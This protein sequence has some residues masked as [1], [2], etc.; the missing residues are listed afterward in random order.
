MSKHG[1][2][3][4]FGPHETDTD[5]LSGAYS[6]NALSDEERTAFEARMAESDEIRTE[7]A[8]LN[9]TALLLGR[10]VEPVQPSAAL[11]SSILDL[12]DST[13]QLPKLEAEGSDGRDE[14]TTT[15]AAPAPAEKSGEL[16]EPIPLARQ[17]WFM[18]PAV[19]LVGAAA[20]VGLFFGG[21]AVLNSPQ[22]QNPGTSQQAISADASQILAASDVEHTASDISTGGTAT[23][24]WSSALKRS[25]VVLDGAS[26]LPSS[27]TYQLWYIKGSSVKSAGTVSASS[28]SLTQV[29]QG[30][31]AKGDTVGI[32]VEPN[33]G[34]KQPTTKPIVALQS[35]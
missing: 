22:P 29:L 34:S 4:G 30:D 27:K 15:A 2:T 1:S 21:G 35:A 12:I 25:V 28:N 9:E 17:R 5:N 33:G 6:L 13:P 19:L 14:S 23:L 20:A 11:R 8:E 3:S 31:M 16:L 7:V 18:R 10:A 26:A 24:Y 32:T